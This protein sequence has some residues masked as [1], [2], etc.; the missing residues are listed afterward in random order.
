MASDRIR[1]N[2]A[3]PIVVLDTSAAMT[4]FEF[5]VDIEDE[6]TKILGEYKIVVPSTV[7]G[8]LIFLSKKGKGRK[9]RLAKPALGL[10]RKYDEIKTGGKADDDVL[11]VALDLDGIVFTNDKELRK[12]AKDNSL[13]TI[14]L[15][16]KKRLEIS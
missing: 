4:P 9:K 10:V 5:L 3:R 7:V 8:E 2:R 15:R 11:K 12:R 14:F 6:L 1:R 16:S 13:K